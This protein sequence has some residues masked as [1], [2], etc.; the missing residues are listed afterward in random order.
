MQGFTQAPQPTEM[1]KGNI[2]FISIL[3]AEKIKGS[4]RG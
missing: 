2:T 1:S 3:I 4:K